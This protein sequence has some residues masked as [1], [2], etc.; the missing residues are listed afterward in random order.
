[1]EIE[2]TRGDAVR[3][4]EPRPGVATAVHRYREER[5]VILHPSDFH[6]LADV[7][8]LVTEL[9]AFSPIE[10]SAAA[11]SAHIESDT[12]GAAIVDPAKLDELFGE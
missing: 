7:E 2:T 8:Q 1:M 10:P 5:A 9:S 6:R 4:P 12:P 11:M 3:I